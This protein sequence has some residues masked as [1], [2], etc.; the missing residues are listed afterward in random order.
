[1]TRREEL[2]QRR[3]TE[4]KE[5]L[6]GELPPNE[7]IQELMKRLYIFRGYVDKGGFIAKE[8]A[9]E[10]INYHTGSI[11]AFLGVSALLPSRRFRDY[12]ERLTLSKTSDSPLKPNDAFQIYARTLK[13][14][15]YE[16]E[17]IKLSLYF[18]EYDCERGKMGRL[19]R[20]IQGVKSGWRIPKGKKFIPLE[21]EIASSYDCFRC[22]EENDFETIIDLVGFA[23]SL[24]RGGSE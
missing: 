23:D 9:L 4:F 8:V 5:I 24:I 7:V 13:C 18:L 12:L 3:E 2:L 20:K 11:Q 22:K 21:R 16:L 17:P 10:K 15:V 6:S 19:F 1:M 14:D